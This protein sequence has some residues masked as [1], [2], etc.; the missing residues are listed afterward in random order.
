MLSKLFGTEGINDLLS[1]PKF[2]YTLAIIA[3]LAII[4]VYSLKYWKQGGKFAILSI[5]I[6]GISALTIYSGININYYY[7]AEGGIHG[8]LSGIFETNKVEVVDDL[9]F[10]LTNI[11]L[12]QKDENTYSAS[13]LSDKVISI[14]TKDNLGIFVNNVPCTAADIHEDYILANYTYTFYDN[15]KSEI[16]TDTLLI[17]I[18]MYNNSTYLEISTKGSSDAI[19]LW[20]SYFNKN[21]FVITVAPFN[22]I[23]SENDFIEGNISNV[24][25]TE[26]TILYSSVFSVLYAE[27]IYTAVYNEFTDE[28]VMNLNVFPTDKITILNFSGNVTMIDSDVEFIVC[29]KDAQGNR[30]FSWEDCSYLSVRLVSGTP[31]ATPALSLDYAVLFDGDFNIYYSVEECL[32]SE[33][34]PYFNASHVMHEMLSPSYFCDTVSFE[35]GSFEKVYIYG[36]SVV[37]P[38]SEDR[39]HI[40]NYFVQDIFERYP[41]SVAIPTD[42]NVIPLQYM[43]LENPTVNLVEGTLTFRMIGETLELKLQGIQLCGLVLEFC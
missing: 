28:Y 18:A 6:I 4:I 31:G 13:M 2:W 24:R 39:Y 21:S 41:D 12:T 8:V 9:N 35:I 34:F 17:N 29:N 20:T 19:E 10:K 16:L 37:V 42:Y 30:F 1:S 7:S 32:F 3:V 26:L 14:S 43:S 23:S 15:N 33:N 38:D 36:Y 11:E 40:E 27:E 5:F 25:P 22:F